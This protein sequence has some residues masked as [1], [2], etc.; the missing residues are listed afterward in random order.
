MRIDVGKG[1]WGGKLFVFPQKK[2]KVEQPL[3]VSKSFLEKS[4]LFF[5]KKKSAIFFIIKKLNKCF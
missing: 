1:K 5:F 2:K 4:L 3:N